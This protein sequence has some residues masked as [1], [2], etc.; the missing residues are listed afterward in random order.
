MEPIGRRPAAGVAAE[1]IRFVTQASFRGKRLDQVLAAQVPG[2]SRR[3]ARLLLELGGVFVEGRRCKLAGRAMT[4]G[5]V[6]TAHMGGALERATQILGKAARTSD[7]ARLPPYEILFEDDDLIVVDKPAGVL[8]APTPESDRNN[9]Q[10]LLARVGDVRRKIF[11][12]HRLDLPTSGVVVFAK[13]DAANTALGEAFRLH[14]IDREYLGIV[15]G[16]FPDQ[17]MQVSQP[18]AGRAAITHFSVLER[19][20][21][22]ATLLGCRLE[23]G[24]T[25]QIRIHC[26]SLGHPV[27][28]DQRHVATEPSGSAAP[29]PVRLALHAHRLGFRHPRTSEALSFERPWPADLTAFIESLRSATR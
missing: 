7:E 27:L 25:H 19:F 10:S 2:L 29:K 26:K 4:P 11:V 18:I 3:K 6:V 13:S 5:E 9:L 28:G 1:S 14:K 8:T 17:V 12:V 24:R 20:G 15:G 23:T 21:T 22:T 16:A